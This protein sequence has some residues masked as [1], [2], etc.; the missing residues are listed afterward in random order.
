MS[1][2]SNHFNLF[3]SHLAE[4][5]SVKRSCSWA[6]SRISFMILYE[7]LPWHY[8]STSPRLPTSFYF[9]HTV[10][11]LLCTRESHGYDTI[12]S[13]FLQKLVLWG[14]NVKYKVM[15]PFIHCCVSLEIMNGQMESHHRCKVIH[16]Q[17]DTKMN[18]S[19]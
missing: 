3:I 18:G 12:I 2:S 13:L 10:I 5:E 16:C 6:S 8:A 17:S 7:L 14:H 1:Q 9:C 11:S 15:E 4:M 19:Q